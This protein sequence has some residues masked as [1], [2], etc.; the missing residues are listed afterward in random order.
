MK[1][2]K[3]LLGLLLDKYE[4]SKD[5]AGNPTNRRILLKRT[6]LPKYDPENSLEKETYHKT[7]KALAEEGLLEYGWEQFERENLLGSVWLC[8]DAAGEAYRR[9]EREPRALRLTA[10]GKMT[11]EAAAAATQPW[12]CTFLQ[13]TLQNLQ[14]KNRTGPMM[15]EDR[16]EAGRLTDALLA[17]DRLMGEMDAG[18]SD[19]CLERVFSLRCFGDSKYFEKNIRSRMCRV[20]R[21]YYL[22]SELTECKDEEV[23][24]EVGLFRAP[25]LIEFC[26]SLRGEIHGQAVDF[27]A[28][29]DGAVIN[30]PTANA[31]KIC[32]VSQIRRV[33]F[34]ENKANYVELALRGTAG[35]DTLLVYHGGFYSR[36]K[37]RFFEKLYRALAG[38]QSKEP[39]YL[40][41]SDRFRSPADPVE[42][43]HWGDIDLGGF[44]M[45]VRLQK[46]IIPELEP[47]RMDADTLLSHL[48]QAA[49]FSGRYRG[50]LEA[51]LADPDYSPFHPV[52][53]IMLRE[54]A[55]L[56][57]EA[58]L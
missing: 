39:P 34:I 23:L 12:L 54:N 17:L 37:G 13:D 22:P 10:V 5:G 14:D 31:F 3:E 30:L 9:L 7:V 36:G 2:E 33:I 35:D 24:G 27:S 43:F 52:I 49:G 46:N 16:H 53:A 57:Q 11:K 4:R 58:L 29:R 26:G 6:E 21:N 40:Q 51:L 45:F 8:K 42:F 56:E 20:L 25:E 32:D 18:R 38:P 28:F 41:A 15:P 50:E 1:Y 48:D 19:G 47:C 55:R 44:R